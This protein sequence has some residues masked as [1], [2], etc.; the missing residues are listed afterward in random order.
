M[1]KTPHGRGPYSGTHHTVLRQNIVVHSGWVR[2]TGGAD[3]NFDDKKTKT[4]VCLCD[5]IIMCLLARGISSCGLARAVF[6]HSFCLRSYAC[7]VYLRLHRV[8]SVLCSR[9]KN[10]RRWKGPRESITLQFNASKNKKC[11]SLE[12]LGSLTVGSESDR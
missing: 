2:Y 8:V 11:K 4:S 5:A 3:D 9:R 1:R 7:S 10:N 6:W 12:T